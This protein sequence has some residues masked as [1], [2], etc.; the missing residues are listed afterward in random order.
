MLHLTTDQNSVQ[1]R[2]IHM[3]F[4]KNHAKRLSIS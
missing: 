4:Y 3:R 1:A 2:L